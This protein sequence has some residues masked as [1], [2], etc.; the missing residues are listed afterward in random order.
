MGKAQHGEWCRMTWSALITL[1]STVVML[2]GALSSALSSWRERKH[3]ALALALVEGY[4]R[5][6]PDG[7]TVRVRLR[8]RRMVVR[9]PRRR[10]ARISPQRL[11]SLAVL[12]AGRQ[13]AGVSGE[14]RSHL[15]GET[16]AGLSESRQV[17]AAA[18]FMLAAMRYRLRDLADLLWPPADAV[19]ASRE[20]SNLA[21]LIPTLYVSVL[22]IR[23]GGLI[24]LADH[25]EDAAVVWG[26]GYA[27]IR[28]GRWWRGVK[29]PKHKPRR[30]TE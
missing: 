1:A 28:L 6:L 18:G 2:A 23:E 14:W 12:I 4:T 22:F 29:P 7:E 21:A 15:A 30:E 5:T 24:G 3:A 9:R 17:R 27:L 8:Y 10:R 26:G 11:T 25:L 13:R 20:L 19:L 16:G